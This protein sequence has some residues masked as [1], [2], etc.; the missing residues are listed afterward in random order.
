MAEKI[1]I[2]ASESVPDSQ[3]GAT[4]EALA[5]TIAARRASGSA[6]SYTAWLLEGPSDTLLKKLA[7][8][9]SEVMLAAR[10][11]EAQR[12][13]ANLDHL[14]YEVGDVAY[15]LLV[16]MERYGISLDELAAELNTRMNE[17]ERPAGAVLLRPEN[18]NRGK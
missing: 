6:E 12:N 1:I 15:H 3:I 14:R 7:E 13:D 11:C 2:P 16:V 4:L 18:V 10:D 9:A 17:E 8:E 5:A